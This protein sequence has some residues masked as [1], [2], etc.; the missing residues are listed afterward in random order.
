MHH[1]HLHPPNTALHVDDPA[2][3]Q[4]ALKMRLTRNLI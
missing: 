3:M 1:L 4:L 2:L